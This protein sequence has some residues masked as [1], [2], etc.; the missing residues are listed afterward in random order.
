MDYCNL[1]YINLSTVGFDERYIIYTNGRVYDTLKNQYMN[2]HKHNYC[3][4]TKDGKFKNIALKTLYRQCFNKNYC[5]D[6][7]E[8]LPDEL[9]LPLQ[10]DNDYLVSNKG[11]IKSYKGYKA[12]EL[13]QYVNENGYYYVSINCSNLKVSRLVYKHFNPE[14]YSEEKEVHHIN[15]NKSDNS[16]ENLMC[17]TK[18]EHIA[19]HREHSNHDKEIKKSDV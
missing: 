7:I 19:W 9:W 2:L 13:S 17:L 12:I 10:E 5:E 6:D 16:I 11:R 8:D 3:L 18:D 14:N 15:G 1:S 4:K